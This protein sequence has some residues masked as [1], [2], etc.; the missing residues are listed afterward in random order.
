M[1]YSFAV[2]LGALGAGLGEATASS[3]PTLEWT[4][5]PTGPWVCPRIGKTGNVFEADDIL[6]MIAADT[7][8]WGRNQT[9]NWSGITFPEGVSSSAIKGFRPKKLPKLCTQETALRAYPI[10]IVDDDTDSS[11]PGPYR[12]MISSAYDTKKNKDG[13][14]HEYAFCGLVAQSD[15]SKKAYKACSPKSEDIKQQE[16]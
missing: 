16:A 5:R 3:S 10:M 7:Y 14:V 8:L 2:A 9:E 1:K 11:K 4:N 15:H 12:V 6:H 13:E